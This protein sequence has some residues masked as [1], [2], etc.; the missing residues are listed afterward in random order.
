METPDQ[1]VHHAMT[2]AA[3]RRGEE[4]EWKPESYVSP[5]DNNGAAAPD[6][7]E[8]M[9]ARPHDLAPKSPPGTSPLPSPRGAGGYPANPLT[10]NRRETKT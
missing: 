7:A 9:P 2:T 8:R 6:P 3:M 5:T 10:P 1:N 4:C